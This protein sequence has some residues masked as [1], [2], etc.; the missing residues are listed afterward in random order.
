M[1]PCRR[2][3]A[4]LPKRFA[5]P[6]LAVALFAS[7]LLPLGVAGAAPG[8]GAPTVTSVEVTSDAG[9]DATYVL[10]DV[11]QVTVTFSEPVVVDTAGGTPELAIDMD[12][13]GWGLKS[14]PY[15]DGSG[16][17]TLVF[18]HEVVQPNY[19]TQGIAVLADSLALGGGSIRSASSGTDAALG[20]VGLNHDADHKVD[21]R[22]SPSDTTPPQLLYGEID[23]ASMMLVFSELLDPSSVGGGFEVSRWTGSA[24]TSFSATGGAEVY[25]NTVTVGLGEGNP[26]ATA[27]E[28]YRARYLWDSAADAVALQ[29]L[30]GNRVSAHETLSQ[31]RQATQQLPL[32]NLTASPPSVTRVVVSSDAGTDATYAL[33]ESIRVAVTFNQ[34]VTVDTAGG[35]PTVTIDMDP[36]AWGRKRAVYESGSGTRTLTFAY[37][38]VEPNSSTQGVA[39]REN[40][41]RLRG[42]V[43]GSTASGL[44]AELGH[45]GLDHDPAHKVDWRLAR[46]TTA[47]WL[48]SGEIDGSTVRLYFS[49]AL[50]PDAIGGQFMVQVQI[51]PWAL[52]SFPAAGDVEIDGEIVTV[53]LGAAN[54]A[55]QAGLTELNWAHY[56][57]P[58]DA[59]VEGLRD[60]SGN[61][62]STPH[63]T[64]GQRRTPSV[65]LTNLTG[66][67]PDCELAAPSEVSAL[68]IE[69]GAVIS[70]A[71]PDG[72]A[73]GCEATGFVVSASSDAGAGP[74]VRID[75]PE[76][77]THVMRGLEPGE[78]RFAASVEY[79]EGTS[80][81]LVTAQA[82]TVPDSCI[83]ATAVPYDYHGIDLKV[84]SVNGTGCLPREEY[85]VHWKRSTDDYW[86]TID[87][88]TPT[89][90]PSPDQPDFRWATIDPYVSYDFKIVAFDAAGDRYETG[91][92]SSRVVSHKHWETADAN[93][94]QNVR[95]YTDNDSGM[96]IVWDEYTAPAGRTVTGMV[97]E[98]RACPQRLSVCW[99]PK[100]T[101]VVP[102]DTEAKSDW[103]AR[104]YRITGLTDG[105]HYTA[106]I[107]ARTYADSDTTQTTTDA[108][109]VHAPAVTAWSEPTQVWFID[110]TPNSNPAIGRTFMMIETNKG[111]VSPQCHVTS[112]EGNPGTISCPARTLVSLDS[113]GEISVS[114]SVTLD[115]QS[116]TMSTQEGRADGP[117]GFQ[118]RASRGADRSGGKI[119]LVWDEGASGSGPGE[120]DGYVVQHRK[121]NAD[122]TWPDWPDGE[123]KAATDRS[124]TFT[125][126]AD[127]V[128]QVRARSRTANSE[129]HD[130][131]QLTPDQTV[132]RLGFT[133]EI[134][135]IRVDAARGWAGARFVDVRPGASESLVVTWELPFADGPLPYAYQVRHRRHGGWTESPVLTPRNVVRMCNETC[136]NP[137][138]YTITGL[139]GGLKYEVQIRARSANGWSDWSGD[140][141]GWA[142]PND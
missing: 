99:G 26:P 100:M 90:N 111:W 74:E 35:T 32:R 113:A 114:S 43:I 141:N 127:G 15:E 94:P 110:D 60:G 125:G 116:T 51:A 19:S 73:D 6:L 1:P 78:Y 142:R 30:A 101:A 130:N 27:G 75:D 18:A 96:R 120:I 87:R 64:G 37:E 102:F 105:Q 28:Q 134:L 83:T 12:P 56:V 129:D 133:S 62:V 97:V 17:A 65:Q 118:V 93:S 89:L 36:A 72:E 82:N 132:H 54:P 22:R 34:A 21:W 67:E 77:R 2:P 24:W 8:D 45:A 48:V 91:V 76:A 40:S 137:R 92:F 31:G 70:W 108:W 41:M 109:S 20:H 121:R 13:A 66:A 124:H 98:W 63:S 33:G 61:P 68:G 122:G 135:T 49:E 23:G 50:D 139:T 58:S 39:V 115:G 16:T 38:V 7:A 25:E 5:R 85:G 103:A 52:S 10:G 4:K 106:R 42:G 119:L 46:D 57:A 131:N 126:L 55:A 136:V 3:F 9:A 79:I 112:T 117:P 95:L 123:V 69:R 71:L 86:R 14:V 53:G 81:E 47:P 29:D 128:Y 140:A 11:I 84:I 107:A 104:R 80:R 138:T 59:A 44:A 88:I